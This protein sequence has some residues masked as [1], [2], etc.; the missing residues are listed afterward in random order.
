MAL[1]TALKRLMNEA[2]AYTLRKERGS[3]KVTY[4]FPIQGDNAM[5]KG[6]NI[7]VALNRELAAHY[8]GATAYCQHQSGPAPR[9]F[10]GT[11]NGEIEQD[12]REQGGG[13]ITRIVIEAPKVMEQALTAQF[14]AVLYSRS[15][16]KPPQKGM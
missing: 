12:I 14:D 2:G 1:D 15:V 16:D 10:G 8:P 9:M 3:N 11:A 6:G 4:T 13:P 7:V 5:S